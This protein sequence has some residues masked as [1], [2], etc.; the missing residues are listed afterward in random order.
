MLSSF[1]A[2]C[3]ITEADFTLLPRLHSS[4]LS[5]HSYIN[6][7]QSRQAAKLVLMKAWSWCLHGSTN[8]PSAAHKA[9]GDHAASQKPSDCK[10][11]PFISTCSR[12][13]DSAKWS[14]RNFHQTRHFKELDVSAEVASGVRAC[15]H[16]QQEWKLSEKSE[17][18][19]R[20]EEASAHGTRRV[21]A[22]EF[23]HSVSRTLWGRV[24]SQAS[25]LFR[26][27]QQD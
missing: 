12:M 7:P 26:K 19:H 25:S 23:Q 11:D 21:S 20:Q 27:R 1:A 6:Q 16:L 22:T 13:P 9:G 8:L 4:I 15:F 18:S 14:L 3:S 2:S 10:L 17:T 24:S 5:L